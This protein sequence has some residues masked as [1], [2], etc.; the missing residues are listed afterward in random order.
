MAVI[1]IPSPLG[2]IALHAQ[3]GAL[4]TLRWLAPGETVTRST[5]AS[6]GALLDTAAGQLAAYFAGR[7]KAF[8][9]PLA[10]AGTPY[11]QQ[12][13]R[14]LRA[15]PFGQTRRYGELAAELGSAAQPVGQACGSNPLPVF[16][17][18]HRV[19]AANGA[20]G[21]SARGGIESKIFLLKLEK[22]WP[23]LV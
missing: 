12:V 9:L 3:D 16:I 21:F 18:C 6:D 10:P 2:P 20:G 15:I 14:A 8:D 7:L 23:W 22:A 13:Y 19:L 17:P 4:T 1:A 5:S 11:Q